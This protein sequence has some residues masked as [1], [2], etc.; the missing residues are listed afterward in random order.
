MEG[1]KDIQTPFA[2]EKAETKAHHRRHSSLENAFSIR[3]LGR[4]MSDDE[5]NEA[6]RL[7]DVLL[8]WHKCVHPAHYSDAGTPSNIVFRPGVLLRQ[9]L[10][11]AFRSG[12]CD[13]IKRY[14]LTCVF[15]H[16]MDRKVDSVDYSEVR[17]FFADGL[18]NWQ[19]HHRD[20]AVERLIEVANHIRDHFL[21][22]RK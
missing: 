8:D 22:P 21:A 14:I 12:G 18:D 3:P 5:R 2:A 13:N 9:M 15:T 1:E 17:S 7:V 20:Q 10:D 19:Q 16:F 4:T 11:Q 6:T